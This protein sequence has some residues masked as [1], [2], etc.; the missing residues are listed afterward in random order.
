MELAL[1]MVISGRSVSEYDILTY[2]IDSSRPTWC[3]LGTTVSTDK[4][5]KPGADESNKSDKKQSAKQSDSNAEVVY[6]KK[7]VCHMSHGCLFKNT[8]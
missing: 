3:Y 4:A 2:C 8:D 5:T 6:R 7:K 1:S